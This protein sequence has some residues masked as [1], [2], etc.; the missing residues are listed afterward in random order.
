MLLV[1]DHVITLDKEIEWIWTLR[2][3]LPKIIF[4]FNRY[5]ITALLFQPLL[6]LGAAE[7]LIIIRVC[8]LLALIAAIAVQILF[9]RAYRITLYYEFLPGCWTWS[10]TATTV[11]QWPMWTTFLVVES[12]L[13]L[14]AAYKLLSYR[15]QMNQVIAVL[16]RDSIAYAIVVGRMMMNIRG[17]ILDDPEHTVHLKTLQFAASPNSVS[18]IQ[19]FEAA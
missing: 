12:V 19:E 18:E 7:L 9:G 14:L 15:N 5:V 3:R 4:I 17:L 1:Y 13:V 6:N 10:P 2:W 8:S 11:T 16:A